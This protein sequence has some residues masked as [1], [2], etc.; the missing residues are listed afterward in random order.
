[1]NLNSDHYPVTLHIPPNTLLARSSPPHTSIPLRILNPIPPE[2]LEKFNIAFFEQNSTPINTLTTLLESHTH[3]SQ[4]QWLEACTTLD[5]IINQISATIEK[6]CQAYPLPTLT[7]RTSQQGGFLPRKLAKEWQRCLQTYH[8][9]R[10]TIYIVLHDPLWQ[11]HPIL[12]HIRNYPHA[13]IP[14]PPVTTAHPTDWIDAIATIA[15]NANKAARKITTKYTKDCIL[16]AVSKYRQ[17]YEKNPKKSTVKS[18]K[19]TNPHL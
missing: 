16:K 11:T 18:S 1:M 15:K 10:K 5:H 3:L 2:N 17:L 9:I 13:Q 19:T 8:L 12:N 6:T 4:D 7:S 14:H